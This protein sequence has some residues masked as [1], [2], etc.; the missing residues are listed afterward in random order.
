[1]YPQSMFWS[2]LEKIGIPLHTP[3]FLY[4]S[5]VQ[6]GIYFM[7]MFSRFLQLVALIR[8]L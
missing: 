3:V 2:K 1:M 8:D 4:K 7:D 5:G 6:G